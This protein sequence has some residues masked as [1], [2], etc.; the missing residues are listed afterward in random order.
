MWRVYWEKKEVYRLSI[1]FE[2]IFVSLIL[3]SLSYLYVSIWI[4]FLFFID[5]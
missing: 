5:M 2:E 4:A 3:Q 1:P